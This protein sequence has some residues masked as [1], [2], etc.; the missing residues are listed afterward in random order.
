MYKIKKNNLPLSDDVTCLI[1]IIILYILNN[2]SEK[3]FINIK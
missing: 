2:S 1:H 3:Y